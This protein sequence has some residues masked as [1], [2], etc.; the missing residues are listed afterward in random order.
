MSSNRD[1]VVLPGFEHDYTSIVVWAAQTSTNSP[2]S[3]ATD[4]IA[5]SQLVKDGKIPDRVHAL[6]WSTAG[7]GTMTCTLRLWAYHPTP[8][9]W[10]PLG[11]G[12]AGSKGT[13]NLGST[14]DETAADT[15]AH[16]EP[17]QY[18]GPFSRVYVEIV[19]IGGTSTAVSCSLA[20]EG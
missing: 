19:A 6:I 11:L 9:K 7:S 15:I 1:A 16:A 18:L 12:A 5:T 8:A 14:I 4:G 17:I 3:A 13:L 20:L 10:F 2:P